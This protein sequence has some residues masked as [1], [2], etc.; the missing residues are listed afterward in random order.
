MAK[1]FQ[2]FC[3]LNIWVFASVELRLSPFLERSRTPSRSMEEGLN[4]TTQ[5][6]MKAAPAVEKKMA[7]NG[8]K[9]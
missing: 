8:M 9:I 3:T 4:P 5:K 2:I 6:N 7:L 1:Q